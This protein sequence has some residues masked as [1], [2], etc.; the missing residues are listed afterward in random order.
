MA[1]NKREMRTVRSY[2]A[3]YFSKRYIIRGQWGK[4]TIL[5]PI[6]AK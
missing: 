1:R 6:V 5:R 3:M 4:G 2:A